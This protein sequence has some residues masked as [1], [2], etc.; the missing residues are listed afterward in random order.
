MTNFEGSAT[1]QGRTAALAQSTDYNKTA[2]AELEKGLVPGSLTLAFTDVMLHGGV[3]IKASDNDI[4]TQAMTATAPHALELDHDAD[5]GF[6][7]PAVLSI[8]TLA[9]TTVGLAAAIDTA[10]AAD[11]GGVANRITCRA[12]GDYIILTNADTSG[13]FYIVGNA[14]TDAKFVTL[15]GSDVVE[16][17]TATPTLNKTNVS[18]SVT[19]KDSGTDNAWQV[20]SFSPTTQLLVAS[21]AT[22][23]DFTDTATLTALLVDDAGTDASNV[24]YNT[25]LFQL[26]Y[27][28]DLDATPANSEPWLA[29]WQTTTDVSFTY[30]R[31]WA[32]ATSATSPLYTSRVFSAMSDATLPGDKVYDGNTLLGRVVSVGDFAPSATTYT[33][34][35]LVLSEYAVSAHT[36]ITD[37]YI[38][39]ENLSSSDT[40]DIDAEASYDDTAKT[41]TIKHALLRDSAGVPATGSAAVY[42]DYKALRTDVTAGSSDPEMLVFNNTTEV[43]SSIGPISTEN[44]LAWGV[45]SAFLNASTISISALGVDETTADAP[46]GTLD[47]YERALD[48]LEL[49]T[50]WSLVPLTQDREVHKLCD[51]HV[52]N[53]S[54]PANKKPRVV[55]VNQ[56]LPTEKESTLVVSGSCTL[57]DIGGGKYELTFPVGTNVPTSLVGLKDA[58]GNTLATGAGQTYDPADGLYMDLGSDGYKYHVSKTTS[59][60]VVEINTNDIYQPGSGPG[61]SGNDDAYYVTGTT[62]VTAL[63]N[64]SA[65]GESCSLFVRQA[66]ISKSTTTGK[67][68]IVTALGEIAGGTSGYVD[69]RVRFVQP[70]KIGMSENGLEVS[71]PGYYA[72]CMLAGMRGQLSPSQ[73]FTNYPITGITRPIGSSDLFSETHMATAA[74]GG[75]WWLVQDAPGGSV[76]TRHQLTTDMTSLNTRE[77]SVVA[78]IDYVEYSIRDQI[79]RFIG[80]YNI[81]KQLLEAVSLGLGGVLSGLEGSIVAQASLDEIL[82]DTQNPDTILVTVSITPFYAAN[83]ISVT[84]IV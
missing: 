20:T 73:P 44:P 76:I 57:A 51:T 65:T 32:C 14:T 47:S 12:Y 59:A 80:R 75:V 42:I 60:T 10:I 66:A 84:I 9:D 28:G 63:G 46:E 41:F 56:A 19:W 31:G 77:D 29:S 68:A 39:A 34:A 35:Q 78:A 38:R 16:N 53:M 71:V 72:C 23:L 15:F 25:G 54:L 83:K 81:N 45:Y 11:A 21:D 62:A 69:K 33:G 5:G 40:R 17:K 27:V 3:I 7:S 61:T 22:D 74:A 24:Q 36:S 13:S 48:F 64:F 50:L 70:E 4:S 6:N 30:T 37:W 49:K 18:G 8:T 1:N 79:S 58:N 52:S 67:L 2:A 55:W 43:E 26:T 82:Q